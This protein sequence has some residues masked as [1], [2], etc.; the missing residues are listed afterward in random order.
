VAPAPAV[1]KP[2]E[3][4]RPAPVQAAITPPARPIEP[5]KPADVKPQ[6]PEQL[7]GPT[8][9]IQLASI[10][11]TTSLVGMGIDNPRFP[12]IG[13]VW[14]YEFLNHTTKQRGVARA[15]VT[16]VSE[17]GIIETVNAF[18]NTSARVHGSG[19]HADLNRAVLNFS[20]YLLAFGDGKPGQAWRSLQV[21]N[22]QWCFNP[23]TNCSFDA[24][25]VGQEKVTTPAGTFDAV[26]V[27]IDLN[28][29]FGS[30][31]VWREFRYW[32]AESAKRIVK[33][34]ART[35]LGQFGAPDYDLELI[36]LKLN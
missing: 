10:A 19:A 25:V 29:N 34:D 24:K 1:S 33:A 13:D 11:P 6:E 2:V 31:R 12:K 23:G 32:Y 17:E 36:Y 14:Q 15:E 7:A 21:K 26:K 22:S 4:A 9:P 5:P 18:G 30:T 28:I 35:K 20:P 3:P 8:G 27:V 16:A